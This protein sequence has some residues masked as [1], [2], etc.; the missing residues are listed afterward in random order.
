MTILWC[1]AEDIDFPVNTPTQDWSDRTGYSRTTINLYYGPSGYARSTLF[2]GGGVTTVWLSFRQINNP[3]SAVQLI[4]GLGDSDYH[5]RGIW[6]SSSAASDSCAALYKYN[7][8][9]W[10]E[11]VAETGTALTGGWHKWDIFIDDYDPGG[12]SRT[13]TAYRDGVLILTY[14]GD[15]SMTGV[16]H[17]DCVHLGYTP[18]ASVRVTEFIV[19]DEDTRSFSLVTLYPN[20]AG[21]ANAWTGAYTDIDEVATSDADLAYSNTGDQDMQMKV[22]GLPTGVFS[23]KAVMASAR[24][25]R[26]AGSTPDGLALGIRN[27]VGGSLDYGSKQTLTTAWTTYNRLMTVNPLTTGAWTPAEVEAVQLNLRAKT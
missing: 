15:L 17:F 8:T 2:P 5:P 19:A 12:A 23:V 22:S 27:G 25:Y 9:T 10:T 4:A 7:G 21:D 26:D 16:T 11:L 6:L 1:G 13:V 18:N 14:T 3:Q 24:A 20:A